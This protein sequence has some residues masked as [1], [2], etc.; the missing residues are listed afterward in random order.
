MADY[1]RLVRDAV[2]AETAATAVPPFEPLRFRARRRRVR[3]A[4]TAAVASAAVLAGVAAAVTVPPSRSLFQPAHREPKRPFFDLQLD[5]AAQV[6]VRECLAAGGFPVPGT[7][8]PGQGSYGHPHVANPGALADRLQRCVAEAGYGPVP[9]ALDLRLRTLQPCDFV[10]PGGVR[11]DQLVDQA[12]NAGT[13]WSVRVATVLDGTYCVYATRGA[14]GPEHVVGTMPGWP[15]VSDRRPVTL[16][17]SHGPFPV[18]GLVYGFTDAQSTTVSAKVGDRTFETETHPVEGMPWV[19]AYAL[20][21]VVPAPDDKVSFTFYA[22]D[23]E[24]IRSMGAKPF[25]Q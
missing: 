10:G 4:V 1:E 22:A 6:R 7:D 20:V 13:Q 14:S 16:A 2:A 25:G 19:R 12:T 3:Q 11:D 21:V 18:T 17:L 24:R 15:S 5:H 8:L 9:E 23:G